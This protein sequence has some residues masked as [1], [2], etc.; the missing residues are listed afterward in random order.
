MDRGLRSSL[1]LVGVR[2]SA[3]AGKSVDL[4]IAA[5]RARDRRSRFTSR[6]SPATR[7]DFEDAHVIHDG[8]KL[9]PDRYTLMRATYRGGWV[10]EAGESVSF[11]AREGTHTLHFIT[12]LGAT[13]ELAGRAYSRRRRTSAIRPCACTIPQRRTRHAALL[14][15]AVNVDRMER[16]E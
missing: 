2:G 1:L 7:V 10:L 9:Y 6:G 5:R 4:A 3:A 14:S 16:D 12:G 8:G 11:L 13:F 15:G